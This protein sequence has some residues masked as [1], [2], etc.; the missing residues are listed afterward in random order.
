MTDRFKDNLPKQDYTFY[1]MSRKK[2]SNIKKPKLDSKVILN[3]YMYCNKCG[4]N[5]ILRVDNAKEY[6]C[7]KCLKKYFKG[8]VKWKL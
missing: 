8:K 2:N 7:E 6:I 1:S 4:A 5:P 3:K